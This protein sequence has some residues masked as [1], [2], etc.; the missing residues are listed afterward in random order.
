VTPAAR[1]SRTRAYIGLG[2]NLG[3]S[4]GRIARAI[5]A[6]GALPG[7]RVSGVSRLFATAPVGVTD[8]PE[9]R[10]AAVAL[11]VTTPAPPDVA[12]TDLLIALKR[13]ERQLGRRPSARWGPREIDLDLLLFGRHRLALDRP[14]A[15]RSIDAGLDRG[16]ADRLL[17]VPHR[18]AVERLFVLAPLADLAPRL[19]PPGW[20]ETVESARRRRL[21]A[22][23]EAAARPIAR[24]DERIAEWAA[25][26][27]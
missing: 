26:S 5:A 2:S 1:P 21:V 15:G 10:N 23:G 24:W 25:I 13:I 16:K 14:P 3:D 6:L 9:F 18:D 4:A 11:D 19:V 22:E 7:V 12:A 27:T 17:Q 8:Q 20:H